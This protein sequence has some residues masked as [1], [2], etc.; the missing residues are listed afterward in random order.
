MHSI[1]HHDNSRRA[2]FGKQHSQVDKVKGYQDQ[3]FGS[4]HDAIESDQRQHE[5]C[6][7]QHATVP[8]HDMPRQCQVCKQPGDA[9]DESDLPQPATERAADDDVGGVGSAQILDCR[10]DRDRKLRQVATHGENRHANNE[11]GHAE[12]LGDGNRPPDCRFCAQP[13]PGQADQ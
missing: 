5:Q 2:F 9:Q 1:V 8:K 10:I 13:E 11:L 6:P 3:P 4:C 12:A 7:E